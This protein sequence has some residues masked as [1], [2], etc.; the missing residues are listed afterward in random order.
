M[1]HKDDG[2]VTK[3]EPNSEEEYEMFALLHS[4]INTV[5]S[6]EG[7]NGNIFVELL[8]RELTDGI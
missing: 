3:S 1:V 2:T 6:K 7:S 8:L 4:K 5:M